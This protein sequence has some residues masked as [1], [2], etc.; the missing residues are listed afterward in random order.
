FLDEP[1]EGVDAITIRAI[2]GVLQRLRERGTTIF[3]SSHILEIVERL[4][5]RVAVINEGRLVAEGTIPE[6]RARVA[7]GDQSNLEDL[8][9]KAVGAADEADEDNLSWLR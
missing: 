8:F 3:F 6:L 7:T 5:T 4:C 2:R 1:F 9:L